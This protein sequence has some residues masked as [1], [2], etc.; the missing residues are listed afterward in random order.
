MD[1]PH[2]AI[3]AALLETGKVVFWGFEWTQ[4]LITKNP[5]SHQNT[6]SDATLWNPRGGAK[7]MRAVLPPLIDVDGDGIPEHV[8]LYCSGQTTLPDGRLLVTGG[9]LDLRWAA[10][11][12]TAPPG[13]KVVL[14]FDPRTE[15]WSRAP[16]MSVARW[17]PTQV[18]LADGRTVVLGGYD[19]AKPTQLT[20]NLDV[21]S[22]D[23]R[24]V[25]HAPSGDRE[26]WTYPGLLL[27]PDARVLLAGPRMQDTGLLDP[28]TLKWSPVAPLPQTRGGENLVPVPTST[29]SSPEAM[30]LGGAD[31][32]AQTGGRTVRAYTS[33][34]TFDARRPG[35]GWRPAPSL[36]HPRNWP[37]TVLLPDGSMVI[38]GGG[39]GITPRDVSYTA[40][41]TTRHVEL[42][43][44]HTKRWRV[45]PAQ[46]ED[47][48][49][50]SVA[51]LLPDGRV[52]SAG[53]DANPNRDGDTAELYEPPYLFRGERPRIVSGPKRIAP[54]RSFTLKVTGPVPA[55]VTMLAPGNTTH[56][57]DMQQRF[58]ELKIRRRSTSGG[59]TTLTVD[60]PRSAAVAPPG[61]WML[62]ALSGR[63][64][65]SAARW[66]SLR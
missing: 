58:V 47:R 15:T 43:D 3:H 48:T 55:R 66:T 16:D 14:I 11:G 53:D 28:R 2:Y 54:R 6:S 64:A 22:P 51:L 30:I 20:H 12:Y 27:M 19:D 61:P 38:V 44:P 60:G 49:Y 33:A 57:R 59:V 9:T 65:P 42:W 45:G 41:G 39:T 4:H 62:F 36:H 25:T 1:L 18:E 31:F 37:N 56:A 46:R 13:L 63:G 7:A 8:P 26:T 5:D 29:G 40:D 52:W 17:Y 21:V 35:A 10:H 50:H 23:G 24:S 34:I 32:L